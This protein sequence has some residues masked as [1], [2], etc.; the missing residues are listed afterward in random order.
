M[1]VTTVWSTG[2]SLFLLYTIVCF[3]STHVRFWS[4]HVC[5]WSTHVRFWSTH[6]RFWSTQKIIGRSKTN[7][8][9]SKTNMGRSKTNMGRTETNMGRAKTD[10]GVEQKQTMPRRSDCCHS[11]NDLLN[12]Y[13]CTTKSKALLFH[14]LVLSY[15]YWV[16]SSNSGNLNFYYNPMFIDDT[17]NQEDQWR[18]C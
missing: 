7:M 13:K 9:R 17:T 16:M 18:G 14:L 6:V 15:T 10:Y 1:R 3:W 12:Y 4:T 2:H 5:F 8:S 11:F